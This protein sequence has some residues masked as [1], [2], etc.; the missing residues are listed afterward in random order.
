MRIRGRVANAPGQPR[1]VVGRGA[2][3]AAGEAVVGHVRQ[4][5]G[6]PY[7]CG[8]PMPPEPPVALALPTADAARVRVVDVPFDRYLV[9]A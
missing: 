5:G 6:C 8:M 1:V 3:L 4:A 9:E 7:G 2:G